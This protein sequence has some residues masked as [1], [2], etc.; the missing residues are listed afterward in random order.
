MRISSTSGFPT[1][2]CLARNDMSSRE[3]GLM[4][5]MRYCVRSARRR[6]PMYEAIKES[7]MNVARFSRRV[8]YSVRIYQGTRATWIR[9]W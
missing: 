9:L 6:S 1:L 5:V 8:D 3:Y 4:S 7:S 2:S